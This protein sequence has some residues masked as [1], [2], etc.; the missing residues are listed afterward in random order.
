MEAESAKSREAV[1]KTAGV[2][3]A[4]GASGQERIFKAYFSSCCGGV[5][6]SSADAFSE[7]H[8]AMIDMNVGALCNASPRF[9]WGPVVVAKDELTRRFRMWGQRRSRPEGNMARIER[10]EI[11]TS[12]AFGRPTRFIVTDAKGARFSLN[13]EEIRWAVNTGAAPGTTLNSSFFKPLADAT[14]IQFIEGHGWGHGVGMC[15]W[16]AQSQALQGVPHENIVLSAFPG[17]TLQRAY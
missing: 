16:C 6:Q 9:N 3:V 10:I 5:R 15:Q 17:A 2:V 7:T 8:P 13:G 4:H 14:S 12:N 1:D 11:Q